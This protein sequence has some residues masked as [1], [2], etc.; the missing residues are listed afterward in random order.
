MAVMTF[1]TSTV[2][3]IAMG[4]FM[5]F[6]PLDAV[7]TALSDYGLTVAVLVG[8]TPTGLQPSRCSGRGIADL[9]TCSPSA[10]CATLQG[11]PWSRWRCNATRYS[12]GI[13]NTDYCE[14]NF[15][16]DDNRRPKLF[17]PTNSLSHSALCGCRLNNGCRCYSPF[18]CC[19]NKY[20]CGFI[21]SIL[22][23]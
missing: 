14:P 21:A 23:I 18:I 20:F 3:L 1:A 19:V 12:T 7:A 10:R 11:Q 16:L 13:L 15:V 9:P 8:G 6:S 5:G 17:R 4:V 22:F 2:T